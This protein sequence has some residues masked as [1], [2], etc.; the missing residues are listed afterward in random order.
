MF[1]VGEIIEMFIDED[2]QY[3]QLR[4]NEKGDVI[5]RGYLSELPDELRWAD[6]SSIDNIFKGKSFDGIVLNIYR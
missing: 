5:F 4:D 6:V 3:F 1:T 2:S